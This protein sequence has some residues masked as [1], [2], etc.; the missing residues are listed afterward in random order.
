MTV[1]Q[2]SN[3]G[4]FQTVGELFYNGVRF[5]NAIQANCSVT[6][7]YSSSGR[8]VKYLRYVLSVETVVHEG[9]ISPGDTTDLTLLALRTLL[10]QEGGQLVFDSKG[11]GMDVSINTTSAPASSRTDVIYGP[12]PMMLDWRPLNGVFAAAISWQVEFHVARCLPEAPV[13]QLTEFEYS[14]SWDINESRMTTRTITGQYEVPARSVQSR[15]IS[16]S[17]DLLRDNL[18][19]EQPANFRRTDNYSLSE[20]KRTLSFSIVDTEIPSDDP[21]FPGIINAD[22]DFTVNS[23]NKFLNANVHWGCELSGTIEVAPGVP[24]YTAWLAFLAI[25]KKKRSVANRARSDTG[26]GFESPGDAGERRET[27]TDGY[28]FTRRFSFG[29]QVFG[30]AQTWRVEWLL[31]CSLQQILQASGIWVPVESNTWDQWKASLRDILGSRGS[32][33]MRHFPTDDVIVNFCQN[34]VAAVSAGAERPP[35]ARVTEE[36]EREKCQRKN[37]WI[38][39][40]NEIKCR[41]IYNHVYQQRLGEDAP[42][43]EQIESNAAYFG[44]QVATI[45]SGSVGSRSVPVVH[46]RGSSFWDCVM[47]GFAIRCRWKIPKPEL[48]SIGGLTPLNGTTDEWTHSKWKDGLDGDPIWIARW[49]QHYYFEQKPTGDIVGNI[50]VIADSTMVP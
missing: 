10:L 2:L 45:A 49:L 29:E 31:T 4:A 41:R 15:L 26:R 47:S 34:P 40:V 18:Q 11:F 6:P 17:A 42:T 28:I 13:F 46:R 39:F 44:G 48:N 25:W 7:V 27:Q 16:N 24:K 9:C 43:D 50:G 37:S 19:I 30:R 21:L 1:V 22:V 23:E 12:K 8:T 35:L 36:I 33:D 5:N 32:A 20:D 38:T 14:V 3:L